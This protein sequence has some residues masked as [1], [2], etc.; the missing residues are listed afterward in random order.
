MSD[1]QFNVSL[2]AKAVTKKQNKDQK[3]KK[4]ED[5]KEMNFSI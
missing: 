2:R 1:H 3:K 5:N 4:T